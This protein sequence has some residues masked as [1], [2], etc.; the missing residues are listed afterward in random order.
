MEWCRWEFL[1]MKT[2]VAVKI[3]LNIKENEKVKETIPKSYSQSQC[4]SHILFITYFRLSYKLSLWL[5]P[6]A[7]VNG[8]FA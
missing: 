1:K 2:V 6:M 5:R 3:V 7:N 8:K 4:S